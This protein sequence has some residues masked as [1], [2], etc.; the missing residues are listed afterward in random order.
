MSSLRMT[1]AA[2]VALLLGLGAAPAAAED[3]RIPH[4]RYTLPNG[5]EVILSPDPSVP[6]VSVNVWYHVGSGY[7]TYGKSGFAHLFEHMLFQGS[8]HVGEDKHFETLKV[9]GGDGVN[10]TT[11]LDRTN[12]FE[13]VPSNQLDAALW[14][15]SDRMAYILPLLTQKSLDNQI[16]V[17]RNERRQR[18]DN[19]PYGKAR[20]ALYEALYPGKHPYRYLTIGRHEDLAG[21]SLEDVIGFF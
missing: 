4:E 12:Y 5:L 1:C 16:E 10:G 9:I 19:V 14:L 13:T 18:Y 20:F 7:E 11:N 8:K 3:P 17:V 2:T 6:L 21:A 15:E